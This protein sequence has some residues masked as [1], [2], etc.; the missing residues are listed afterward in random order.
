MQD[1]QSPTASESRLRLQSDIEELLD[2]VDPGAIYLDLGNTCVLGHVPLPHGIEC[3]NN[4]PICRQ[5]SSC[6]HRG[7]LTGCRPGHRGNA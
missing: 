7:P 1:Q 2:E 4:R 3:F 5:R 6:G